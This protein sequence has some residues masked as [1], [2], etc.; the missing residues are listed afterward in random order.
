M[1]PVPLDP[2]PYAGTYKLIGGAPALDFAGGPLRLG[3]GG[4]VILA[5]PAWVTAELL[6]GTLAPTEFR[7]IAKRAD[8]VYTSSRARDWLKFKCE[9]GQELVIGG[10]TEPEGSRAGFGALLV[11]RFAQR[12]SGYALWRSWNFALGNQKISRSMSATTFGCV[13][14]R[15]STCSATTRPPTSWPR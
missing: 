9:Q 15:S 8:S 12:L 11:G 7:V 10:F 5:P 2:G 4:G 3:P 14:R 6:P 13:A 1:D